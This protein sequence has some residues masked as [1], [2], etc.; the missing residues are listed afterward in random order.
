[1]QRLDTYDYDTKTRGHS[2]VP[3][4]ELCGEGIYEIIK[5]A[6]KTDFIYE[7]EVPHVT[8]EVQ[9][10]FNITKTASYAVQVKNSA[11]PGNTR[12]LQGN[13]KASFT[14]EQLEYFRGK[15]VDFLR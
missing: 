15:R 13:Q 8:G 7:L 11:H 4:A 10:V 2:T 12:G 6:D 3:A 9:E 14:A 1:M 5:H